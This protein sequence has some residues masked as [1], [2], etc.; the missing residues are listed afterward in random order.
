[1]SIIINDFSI[2]GQF[3]TIEGFLDNLSKDILPLTKHLKECKC[4]IFKSVNTYN[5]Q[6]TKSEKLLDVLKMKNDEIKKFKS[7]ISNLIFDD[8]HWDE[9]INTEDNSINCIDEA[10]KKNYILLS[11]K[12]N[13]YTE[14]TVVYNEKMY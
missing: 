7:C 9:H 14:D 12:H 1:M 8:P 10:I 2:D 5:N 4:E 6:I 3:E 11:F 13:L